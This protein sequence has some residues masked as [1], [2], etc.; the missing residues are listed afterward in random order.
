M[1]KRTSRKKAA[2]KKA[3]SKRTAPKRASTG[4]VSAPDA[5]SVKEFAQRRERV[6]KALGGAVGV[7]FSGDAGNTLLGKWRADQ[8]FA[9]LTGITDEPGAALVLDP[10]AEDPRR[11]VTVLLQASDPELEAWDGYREGIGAAFKSKYGIESVQ[12]T[13]YLPRLM[14]QLA[15]RRKRFACLHAPAMPEAKVSPDLALFRKLAERV[16]GVSIEDRT[17]LLPSLRSV[18]SRGEQQLMAR[19]ITATAAG[20][21]AAMHAMRPGVDEADIA[22]ALLR[23]FDDAG[24]DGLGYAPIVGAGINST[25][26]HYVENRGPVEDGDLVLIDAGATFGGYTADITRTFPASGVF[27]K[28]QREIYDIVL[29]AELAAIA[30][31][32]P[33]VAM[34]EVD[35]AARKVI[36]KAGYGDAFMHGIG[37]QL[38]MDVH[39]AEPDGKLKA[40]MIVTIEPGIYLPEEKIGVRIED[41]ILVTDKGRK[42]LSPMI[43]KDAAE[44]ERLMRG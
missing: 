39:D 35:R 40:G 19:A 28:R 44:I 4:A 20:H 21:E 8:H 41:D 1:A 31:V 25:V 3:V 18:K 13:R 6:L 29:E 33:G 24:G 17:G 38:G 10:N 42:N 5:I 15:R 37:H 14:T 30:K 34:W 12:R 22:K 9:Y 26:L 11:R 36:E 7:V 43:V 32:K 2:T 23:G 27:T 16:V